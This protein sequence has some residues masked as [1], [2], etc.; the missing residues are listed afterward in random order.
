MVRILHYFQIT[1]EDAYAEF[2]G[3][4][5][6]DKPV[7]YITGSKFTEV[8][9]GKEYLYDEVSKT[10]TAINSGN[11]KTSIV[12][13]TVTLGSALTYNGSEQT[14]AVSSVVIGTTTLTENT[15]YEVLDNKGN[16]IGDYTLHIVGKGSYTGI[17]SADWSIGQGTGSVSASPDS[18]SLTAEGDA[19][20][21][22]LTVTGDGAVTVESSDNDVATA[23]ISGTTVTV[24]PIAEG[25]AT[26]TVTLAETE[27]YSGASDTISV[28]VAAADNND[29]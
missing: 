28:T 3:L 27:H 21:S 9:T 12:G 1:A 29:G 22:T 23:S 24:T 6:D 20:S 18:L 13:A 26:I 19:G 25:S 14:K 10:W 4:A 11:G 7:G 8:D 2:A 17:I 5:S 15:D 16:E